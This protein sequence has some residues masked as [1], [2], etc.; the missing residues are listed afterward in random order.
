MPL[1]LKTPRPNISA[2]PLGTLPSH[3]RLLFITGTHRTGAWLTEAFAHDSAVHT[4]IE[5]ALGMANG[6]ARLRD[7]AFDAVL[8]THEPGQ[9]DGLD[10]AEALRGGGSEEPLILL[11]AQSEQEVLPLAFEA[12]ADA[13]VCVNTTTTRS[14]IWIVARAIERHRLIRENRRLAQ[15]EQHRL[16]QEHHETQRM[17][18]EQRS[19]IRDLEAVV[20]ATNVPEKSTSNTEET[21]IDDVAHAPKLLDLPEPLVRHYHELMRA[22]V[23]MGSGNLGD[24][25]SRMAELMADAEI[26]APETMQLH[27][28]VLEEMVKGLGT[29][30]ARHVMT[31]ADLLVLEV[32]VHLSEVY[33]KRYFRRRDPPVQLTLPGFD[34]VAPRAA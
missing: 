34:D 8:A 27:V 1:T 23:I 12:G 17:L 11:G 26:S 16:Q 28:N 14:L 24:D 2:V 30:S 13:Y 5:E 19:L 10:L 33:R 29:R 25:M 15:T 20:E 9:L 32:M 3:L 31:R 18:D 7:E 21:D 6:L 22:Y 4:S